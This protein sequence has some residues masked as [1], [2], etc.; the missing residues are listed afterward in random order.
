MVSWWPGEG[1][2]DDIQ[3]ENE[4]TL[5]NG[6]TFGSG[7]V[8]QAFSFDGTDD[9]VSI[10]NTANMDFGTGDFTID[11]WV[12]FN[13]ISI[14]QSLIHKVVSPF[15]N[16]KGYL[17]ELDRISPSGS[18][19][20]TLRFLA[21]DTTSNE[22]DLYVEVAS[23][24]TG[25][26]YHVTGVRS[27]NTNSLYLDGNLIGSQTAGNNIDTG[28]GGT[29]SIAS[30]AG[31]SDR[32]V[33]GLIDEVEIFNRA[34]S[35]TEIQA[36]FDADSAGKCHYSLN[37]FEDGDPS[38]LV[39]NLGQEA[40]AVAETD[41][42][43]VTQVEFAWTDPS[44]NIET[45]LVAMTL[46]SAESTIIPDEVGMWTVEADFGNG[47]VVRQELHIDFMVIP[48]SAIGVIALMGSSLAAL[49]GFMFWKRRSKS[50]PTDGSLGLGI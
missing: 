34:L 47:I 42:P 9:F 8:G 36:I 3:D 13:S 39:Y 44:A 28:A 23:L 20:P 25:Q 37:L 27:G 45:E 32:F 22:N 40:R 7:K 14:D 33:S 18:V 29:A 30:L 6:A 5:Q 46:G 17:L 35:D 10:S 31:V 48:E 41:D 11:L 24:T 15:P 1:N 49:G 43:V 21:R 2:A 50:N 12:N 4:G 38:D 16:D 26:W 19:S